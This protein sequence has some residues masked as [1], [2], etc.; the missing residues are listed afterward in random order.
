MKM[1]RRC[2]TPLA[3]EA[4]ICTVCG[5]PQRVPK[6]SPPPM[7]AAPATEPE[8]EEPDVRSRLR[9]LL[10]SP[11]VVAACIVLFASILVC[12]AGQ[13]GAWIWL[14]TEDSGFI[15]LLGLLSTSQTALFTWNALSAIIGCV[16]LF[17]LLLFNRR[18]SLSPQA[19]LL[20]LD[21]AAGIQLAYGF[22]Y[23][24]T[25]VGTVITYAR[26][27]RPEQALG[28]LGSELP[29]LLA[30]ALLMVFSVSL[31][32]AVHRFRAMWRTGAR[33]SWPMAFP[34]SALLFALLQLGFFFLHLPPNLFSLAGLLEGACAALLGIALLSDNLRA[35]QHR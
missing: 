32:V 10:S 25:Q 18:P 3:D 12:Q 30:F 29:H 6:P 33:R 11:L 27:G 2:A 34:G 14:T 35:N 15:E 16:G 20:T 17:L 22:F 26:S 5:E 23:A 7:P 9:R 8:A 31:L 4:P 1:C 19:G 21:V 13:I 28:Y 24:L